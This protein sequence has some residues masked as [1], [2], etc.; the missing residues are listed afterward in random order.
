MTLS[1]GKWS[2]DVDA[3][4]GIEEYIPP[5]TS[6]IN[7][8]IDDVHPTVSVHTYIHIPTRS[9]GLQATSVPS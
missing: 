5:V 1:I 4:N 7:K 3:T 6:F 9:H 8:F 2:D